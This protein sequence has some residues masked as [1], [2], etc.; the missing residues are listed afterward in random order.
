MSEIQS[1]DGQKGTGVGM[2]KRVDEGT[3]FSGDLQLCGLH[4]CFLMHCLL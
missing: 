3:L 1:V 4:T 2:R